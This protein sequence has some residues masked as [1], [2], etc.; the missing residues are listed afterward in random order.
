MNLEQRPDYFVDNEAAYPSF[1]SQLPWINREMFRDPQSKTGTGAAYEPATSRNNSRS[2]FHIATAMGCD[3]SCSFCTEAR[4]NGGRGETRRTVNDVVGEIAFLLDSAHEQA[5]VAFQFIEDNVLPPIAPSSV[6]RRQGE[7]AA[8]VAYSH[9]FLTRLTDLR[10]TPKDLRWRGLM[11]LEDY[12]AYERHI[13][14]FPQKLRQSGCWLIGFGIESGHEQV[15]RAL[16]GGSEFVTNQEVTATLARLH[17]ASIAVKGYF[18]IGEPRNLAAQHINNTGQNLVDATIKL[19][20]DASFDIAYFSIY[21]DFAGKVELQRR[22][23]NKE[24]HLELAGFKLLQFDLGE[25]VSSTFDP[26]QWQVMF[27]KKYTTEQIEKYRQVFAAL[28]QSGF[29][30]VDLFKYNDY[31]TPEGRDGIMGTEKHLAK[32]KRAYLEYYGRPNAVDDFEKLIRA[33][34]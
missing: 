27:D 2:E 33:G 31:M 13:N 18:M 26:S 20:I 6:N 21:K 29:K 3:W 15:R 14:N 11:R 23:T 17:D 16:K 32:V 30:F 1:W 19:A 10:R 9:T 25:F 34:Y 4:I 28:A 12:L 24:Q 22:A 5:E 8:R 7:V